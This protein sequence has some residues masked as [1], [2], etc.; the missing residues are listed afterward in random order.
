[1]IVN[2]ACKDK[3]WAHFTQIH[4]DEFNGK[5]VQLENRDDQYSL[6]ALQGRYLLIHK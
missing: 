3:D 4:K 1:M 6:I 2:G 5:E